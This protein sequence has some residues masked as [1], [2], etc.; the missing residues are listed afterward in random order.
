MS[1]VK[2]QLLMPS[3]QH[4]D[5]EEMGS[6]VREVSSGRGMGMMTIEVLRQDLLR[7]SGVGFQRILKTLLTITLVVS[8]N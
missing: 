7:V 8:D 5:E 6:G 1:N 4:D 2:A 3:S